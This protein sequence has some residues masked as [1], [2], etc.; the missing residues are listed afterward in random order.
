MGDLPLWIVLIST[1]LGTGCTALTSS[2]TGRLWRVDALELRRQQR[3]R[4]VLSCHADAVRPS[5]RRA[6]VS[7]RPGGEPAGVPPCP[8]A[9]PPWRGQE[10]AGRSS[11][12]AS[13]TVSFVP[14][15]DSTR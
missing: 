10:T 15:P 11:R 14:S 9:A 12:E 5:P 2:G 1:A 3:F 7:V 4:H 13:S 6:A 8:G